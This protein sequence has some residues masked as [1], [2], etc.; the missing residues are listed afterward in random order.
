MGRIWNEIKDHQLASAVFVVYWLAVCGLYLSRWN[1][2]KNAPDL[3][4][5]VLELHL[6]LPL[7]AGALFSWWRGLKPG[8]ITGGM[9]AG[10]TV[11]AIDFS[12]VLTYG[13][14]LNR[15]WESSGG[16]GALFIGNVAF[17]LASGVIGSVLGLIGAAG[18]LVL[19]SVLRCRQKP[20]LGGD[21]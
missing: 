18:R 1:A 17:L 13:L 19:G 16:K 6:L 4:R 9:A 3:A 11:F 7:A 8:G 5:P 15:F 20:A 2:P 21:A 14:I 10:A 12:L